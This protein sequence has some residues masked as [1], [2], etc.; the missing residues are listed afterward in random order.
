MSTTSEA[1]L[2]YGYIK[3]IEDGDDDED[4]NDECE[5]EESP[6]D[7]AHTKSAH[8]CTVGI[9]GYDENLGYFL[10]VEESLYA[11]EW[12]TV[13]TI[14]IIDLGVK[15]LERPW[16]EMLRSAASEFGIDLSGLASGWHLVCLYF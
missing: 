15:S 4:Y 11:A 16:D 7:S 1:K 8:G 13:K 5:E 6:W 9:H 14:D 10:A 12:D 2:F 3:P